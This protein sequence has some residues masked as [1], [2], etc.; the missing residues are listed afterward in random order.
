MARLS[1]I[2]EHLIRRARQ[3]GI[4]QRADLA[5]GARISVRIV[6][7]VITLAFAR[8]TQPLGATEL[9]TFVT[10][11]RVPEGAQRLPAEGQWERRDVEGRTWHQVAYCWRDPE[12]VAPPVAEEAAA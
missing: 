5:K 1:S 10:H 12:S 11:C 6:D 9:A 3:S 2:A 4:D 8:I 7:G